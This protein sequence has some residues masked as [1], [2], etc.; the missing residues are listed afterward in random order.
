[1]ALLCK[2][3]IGKENKGSAL[4]IGKEA[5]EA[6]ALDNTVIDSTIGMLFDEEG[7]SIESAPHPKQIVRFKCEQKVPVPSI[8]RKFDQTKLSE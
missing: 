7:N 5:R 3:S 4:T 8:L 2:E 1:M 6:K